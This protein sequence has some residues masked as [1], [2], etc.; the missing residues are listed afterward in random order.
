[1]L[2]RYSGAVGTTSYKPALPRTRAMRSPHSLYSQE[3]FPPS[4]FSSFWL[5]YD[6]AI[7]L[8]HSSSG[9]RVTLDIGCWLGWGSRSYDRK[10]QQPQGARENGWGDDPDETAWQLVSR[11][12]E[13]RAFTTAVYIFGLLFLHVSAVL[14]KTGD[15]W[16]SR[17]IY[18]VCR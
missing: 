9:L 17:I 13:M 16:K 12:A 15:Q 14:G 1:M 8:L 10:S 18:Q 7:N 2:H 5:C 3:S 6:T 11:S 4:A